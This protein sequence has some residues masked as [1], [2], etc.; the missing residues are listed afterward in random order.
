MSTGR[1]KRL[2][3]R[4][5]VSMALGMLF[6]TPRFARANVVDDRNGIASQV[7]VVN[8]ARPATTA[9]VEYAYVHIHDAVNE[10]RRKPR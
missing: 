9:I 3:T 6:L 5:F 10:A 2:T 1:C 8:A 4:W 7:I